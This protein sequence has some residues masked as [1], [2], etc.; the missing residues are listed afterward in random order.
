MARMQKIS[1]KD[2]H[3]YETVRLSGVTNMYA[4]GTVI[5]LTGL[6]RTVIEAIQQ[7]DYAALR[8]KYGVPKSVEEAAE[9]LRSEYA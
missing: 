7:S 4:I 9:E 2:F 3:A 5:D 8:E 6:D 1:E